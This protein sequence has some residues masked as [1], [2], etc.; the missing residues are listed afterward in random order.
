MQKF[1][2]LDCCT[3]KKKAIFVPDSSLEI[4]RGSQKTCHYIF[5]L[6]PVPLQ[7]KNV[8]DNRGLENKLGGELFS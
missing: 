5:T 2:Y 3:M 8:S 1:K 4:K 7:N 6:V